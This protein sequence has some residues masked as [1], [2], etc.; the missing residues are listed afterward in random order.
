MRRNLV[1]WTASLAASL[2][3]LGVMATS[4]SV[5]EATSPA[6]NPAA[7][8]G[9]PDYCYQL[10]PCDD[11]TGYPKQEVGCC[12]EYAASIYE[13]LGGAEFADPAACFLTVC[14]YPDGGAPPP[15]SVGCAA[16]GAACQIDS[17][18]CSGACNPD[19]DRCVDPKCG[20]INVENSALAGYEL[21]IK[22][23]LG[24]EDAGTGGT[25][26]T[27]AGGGSGGAGG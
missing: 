27:P 18:C 3:A 11:G 14:P 25:G 16:M 12:S 24:D 13:R 23:R 15:C 26:G 17:E 1:L 10:A 22:G 21:C 7:A 9:A 8:P 2:A 19:S 5:G 6:C 20:A 4:C